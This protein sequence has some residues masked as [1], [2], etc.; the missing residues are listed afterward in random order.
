MFA[1][2]PFEMTLEFTQMI[3]R[4]NSHDRAAQSGAVDERRMTELVQQHDIALRD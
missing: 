4:K 3:M 1:L 2:R